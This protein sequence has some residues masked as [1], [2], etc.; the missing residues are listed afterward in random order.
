[1]I[2]ASE[3]TLYQDTQAIRKVFTSGKL[4][5]DLDKIA[6][7]IRSFAASAINEATIEAR[8]ENEIFALLKPYGYLYQPQKEQPIDT[9]AHITKGRTDSRVGA[10]VIEFKKPTALKTLAGENKAISQALTYLK[11]IVTEESRTAAAMITD[12]VKM[13]EIRVSKFGEESI[14]GFSKFDCDHLRRLISLLL[15]LEESALTSK[16]LIQDFCADYNSGALFS[17]ARCLADKILKTLR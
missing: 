8:F 12:G 16:N 5:S 6:S 2:A 14:S 11:S 3:H 17:L 13:C 7:D 9:P 1:M 4:D 15:S 10:F